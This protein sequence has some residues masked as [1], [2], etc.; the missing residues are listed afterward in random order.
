MAG[1]SDPAQ[2]MGAW[3]SCENWQAQARSRHTA[4]V[5]VCLADGSVRFIR[6]SI[7]KRNWFILLSAADGQVAPN[8]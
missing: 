3:S 2:G 1:F 7:Q 8:D 5:N 4:G 6:D